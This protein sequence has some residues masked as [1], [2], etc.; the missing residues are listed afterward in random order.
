MRSGSAPSGAQARYV[1]LVC[2]QARRMR[3]IPRLALA[4]EGDMDRLFES[5]CA[6]APSLFSADAAAIFV[7]DGHG[8][9]RARVAVGLFEGFSRRAAFATAELAVVADQHGE[10]ARLVAGAAERTF[11]VLY[12]NGL[13]NV[14]W[15]Q[16]RAPRARIGGSLL[17]ARRD[18]TPSFTEDDALYAEV[19]A[20]FLAARLGEMGL[21][22]SVSRLQRALWETA[23]RASIV[24]A[25]D[26]D[27]DAGPGSRG[28]SSR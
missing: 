16:V 7:D 22:R 18:D 2:L 6:E 27:L 19:L 15:A 26:E 20:T 28:D 14:L 25:D 12:H 24:A 4:A 3:A 17:V 21:Q 9:L 1:E 13:H 10:V 8:V 23:R 5:M 11:P